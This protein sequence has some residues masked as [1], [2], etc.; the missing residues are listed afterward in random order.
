M[1]K[2][3]MP[4]TNVRFYSHLTD[5]E[6]EEIKQSAAKKMAGEIAI[7]GS[8]QPK[9]ENTDI[10]VN[11]NEDTTNNSSSSQSRE[12]K[13]KRVIEAQENRQRAL[14]TSISENNKKIIELAE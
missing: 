8:P 12:K 3:K 4:K 14:M 13:I 9:Q 10:K 1:I 7:D 2:N 5:K 11:K 6:A